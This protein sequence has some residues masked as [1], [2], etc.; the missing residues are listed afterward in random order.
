MTPRS[1]HR[2]AFAL[3][4]TVL[5]VALN[6]AAS[7]E[8]PSH[9][10]EKAR[11]GRA[12]VIA[13]LAGEMHAEGRLD[14][15]A[16]ARQRRAIS[17]VQRGVLGRLPEHRVHLVRAFETIPYVAL[18]VDE[19]GLTALARDPDVVAI[20]EDRIE[21]TQLGETIPIVRADQAHAAGFD[22]RGWAVAI[23]DTGVD[24]SHPFLAGK[25]VSEACFSREGNCPNG[26]TTQLGT[27][28]GAPCTYA[29]GCAHGTHVAGI[30]AGSGAVM[31]GVAPNADL[32]S[33]QVFSRFEG[34]KCEGD[35]E[36]P[37]TASYVSDITA[38]LERVFALRDVFSIAAVNIS[39]GGSQPYS[40]PAQCEAQDSARR[41]AIENLRSVGIPTI[42]ASG[43]NGS[44]SGLTAPACLSAAIS[45]GATDD[46]DRVAWFSNSATFLDLLA[47]GTRVLSSV[48]GTG[49]LE[50]Q[51]TSMAAPHVAGAFA[52]LR[53][54]TGGASLTMLLDALSESGVPITDSRNGVTT[55]R[56]DVL[57]ALSRLGVLGGA[58]VGVF[59]VPSDGSRVSGVL[60]FSGW[61][62]DAQVVEIQVDGGPPIRAA[63][64]TPRGDTVATCGDDNNGLSLLFNF[65]LLGDG[66]HTATLL[67]DG[68]VVGTSTFEVATLGAP[69]VR[70]RPPTIYRLEDFGGQDVSVQ[71]S[72][73]LQ[74]FVI[75]GAE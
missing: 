75:V 19:A 62:C 73:P 58:P 48:P 20:E 33:L 31:R 4:T 22:G 65:A 51:G 46:A 44:S 15:E 45:V 9:L 66:V 2:T 74:N 55:P 13:Q 30:V 7:V 14:S 28:A 63:Y 53:Q 59:E 6:A 70:D 56:L 57:G 50:Y 18:D 11:K 17:R 64:G 8:T 23:I 10:V 49:Y 26:Q 52:V 29:Q 35:D 68:V 24:A 71:W 38:A 37:C 21:R 3:S 67:A 61:I 16:I 5:A 43:N 25:V 1:L 72:Q 60:A 40:L 42:V 36:D 47:P 32:I 27:G 39:I 69:F 34:D 41:R 12:R 54:A